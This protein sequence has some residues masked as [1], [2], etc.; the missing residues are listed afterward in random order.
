MCPEVFW[1]D[2]VGTGRFGIVPRPRGGDRLDGAIQF[3]AKAGGSVRQGHGY[4]GLLQVHDLYILGGGTGKL[5]V[6]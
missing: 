4:G 2:R 5:T 1:I 3:L 6:R